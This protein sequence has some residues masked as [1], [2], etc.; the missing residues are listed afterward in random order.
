VTEAQRIPRHRV[1]ILGAG[2]SVRGHLPSAIVRT[3]PH[4]RVLD[5]LLTAFGVIPD[6]DV[7]FVGGYLANEVMA[8]Y[9]QIRFVLNPEWQR[10]GPARSLA[11]ANLSSSESTYASYA[12]VVCRPETIRRMVA[13]KADLVVAVDRLWRQRYDGRGKSELEGAEK[14]ICD[15]NRLIAVGKH[16]PT[17]SA[18]AEFTGLLKVSAEVVDRLQAAL[19]PGR[20]PEQSGV[21]EVLE[22]LLAEG[23]STQVVDVEGEWAEL[24][25]PQDLARF[26][27]GTK[28]ESLE[29][30]KPHVQLGRIG[31]LVV[32]TQSEW[33]AERAEVMRRVRKKF[34][35]NTLIVRS[36]ARSEDTWQCSSAGAFKSVPDVPGG[37]AAA[38]AEA[39]DQVLESYGDSVPENQVLVQEMLTDVAM[40]GVAMTRTPTIGAPY[41]AINF[42]DTTRRTDTVTA[43]AVGELRTVFLHRDADLPPGLPT[44]LGKLLDLLQEIEGLVGHDSLDVEFAFTRDGAA[45][46]L[47]V[48]PIAVSH[49]LPVDDERVAAALQ[50]GA[51]VLH[52]HQEPAPLLLGSSTQFSVMTDWNPAEM[53]GTKP[54]RL[55][56][57]LYR[58]LIT[59]DVWARQRAEAGY[60]DVRP[61][62]LLVDFL[63]HPYVDVRADFNSFIPA[64]LPDDVASRLVDY[65]LDHLTRCPELHDKVE[66]EVLLTCLSFDFDHRL[67]PLRGAG[68]SDADLN[69]LRRSLRELTR[70]II[71]R[72]PDYFAT[73]SEVDQ[74]FTRIAQA[75]AAPLELAYLLLEDARMLGV[76]LFAHLARSAF[77]AMSL[78]RSLEA[79]GCTTRRQ[80]D[81]FLAS[82]RT[83]TGEMQADA[84]RV[85]AGRLPWN[86][87]VER[88][89]HLR[90]G[91]YDICS[92]RYDA[93]PE[94]YLR[95]MVEAARD[96]KDHP[97]SPAWSARTRSAISRQLRSIGLDDDPEAF[98][99][100]L[101]RAIEGRELSKFAFTRHLSTALEALAAFGEAHGLDREDMSHVGI[102]DLLALRGAPVAGATEVLRRLVQEGRDAF[103][104]T[105]AVCLPGQLL[106][107]GDFSCFEQRK[108]EPNYVTQK[109]IRGPVVLLNAQTP[110]DVKLSGRIVLIPN[111]D[112]GFDWLFS[113]GLAGLVTMYGGVNSHMAIRAAE[114]QLP[115]VI[116]LGEL[117]YRDASRARVLELDCAS[118][119]I[120]IVG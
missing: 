113:R 11:L 57:S 89:G 34:G 1:V 3:D 107:P 44:Q 17:G 86:L 25:A 72:T 7:C 39:V 42:D 104:L 69:L 105:Q 100:F 115:A 91:S 94:Q 80:T 117:L 84:R 73:I 109:R 38:L 8:Q 22:R 63:G 78:L 93:A 51:R 87:F 40:S 62:N 77:V 106:S 28:A 61:C 35:S 118:R 14:V 18:V 75:K 83:I 67:R 26:V 79:V 97:R 9:P 101:R 27:L 85:A 6:A 116:G 32:F 70:G 49:R 114:F 4:R 68:F 33:A 119:H 82:L 112:P 110:P 50:R 111:A 16:I 65:Y 46:V 90:P 10:T 30:L 56:F 120:K 102:P 43:G 81:R 47:Q 36:S 15:G 76:P 58:R 12:D 74:R 103:A 48:R 37:S 92:S 13:A 31:E 54:K 96:L 99:R 2:R 24:N 23:V 53:I 19:E 5:W 108:A 71:A 66:F 21:P 55:A 20:L 88:Y 45:H 98:E 41:Y 64:V 60:R 52:E 29:R 59:D 95:P